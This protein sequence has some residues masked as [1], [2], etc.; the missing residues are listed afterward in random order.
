MYIAYIF[1]NKIEYEITSGNIVSD[2]CDHFSQFFIIHI[3]HNT[4]SLSKP[5]RYIRDYS[6]F[7][8][9]K[10]KEELSK[11]NFDDATFE[12]KTVDKSFSFFFFFFL[13]H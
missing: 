12:T 6:T 1:A 13:M 2:I 4:K 11:T 8:E 5:K 10:F 3:K 9:E 7:S